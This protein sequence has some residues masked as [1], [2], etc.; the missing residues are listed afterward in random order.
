MH[1]T[2]CGDDF[3]G[4]GTATS[5]SGLT[6]RNLLLGRPVVIRKVTESKGKPLLMVPMD[7]KPNE[8]VT[9]GSLESTNVARSG[10]G[11]SAY[12]RKRMQRVR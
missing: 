11:T 5:W 2:S 3:Y 9:N 8:P 12:R 10:Q 1:E 6:D 7:W 4:S